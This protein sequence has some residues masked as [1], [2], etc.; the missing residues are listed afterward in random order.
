VPRYAQGTPYVPNDGL[1][2]L[3]KGEAVIPASMN[4]GGGSVRIEVENR[5]S[6][7]I[8]ASNAAVRFDAEGL[9]V[10]IITDDIRRGGPIRSSIAQM[11]TA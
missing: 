11:V 1:A 4:G 7:P 2:F 9:V 6:V 10:R 5:A 8:Q 3:H